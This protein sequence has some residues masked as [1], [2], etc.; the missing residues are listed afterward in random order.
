[1]EAAHNCSRACMHTRRQVDVIIQCEGGTCTNEHHK[2]ELVAG[3]SITQC[4]GNMSANG[5]RKYELLE[6]VCVSN[7]Q[8]EGASTLL[9]CVN[10]IQRWGCISANE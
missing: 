4:Q 8:H 10:I 3:V 5:C 1:M 9:A 7:M 2:Y 6:C